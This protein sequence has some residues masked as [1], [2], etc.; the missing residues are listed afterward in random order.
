MSEEGERDHAEKLCHPRWALTLKRVID[1]SVAV[2]AVVLLSPLFLLIAL[3]IKVGSPGPIFY[4][5]VRAGLRG[6]TFRI[7]KFRSMVTD[8]E[9]L[10][11]PTTG[12]NDARVTG[13]GSFL[14]KTKLDEFPQFINVLTGEMS[15]VGPRPEV[16]EY[17]NAFKGEEKLIL[18]MRPGITDYSSIEFANLDEL[19]GDED[20]DAYFREYIL[21]LKNQLRIKYVKEWS[22]GSDF[23]ILWNT[24]FRVIRRALSS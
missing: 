7:L 20:P 2:L 12:T 4:R 14:R 21:P 13:I 16:L 10:G 22:L 1:L 8:A 5:G 24:L 17:A 11:G 9:Q 15:L 23:V 6:R 18:E 3:L 19:V